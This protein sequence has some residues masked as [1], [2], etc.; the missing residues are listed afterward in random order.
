MSDKREYYRRPDVVAGYDAWRFGSAGGRYVD[1]LERGKVLELLRAVPRDAPVLDMPCGT[2]RLLPHLIGAGF[3]RVT[4]ADASPG[5]LAAARASAPS[6]EL[7]QQDALD[8]TFADAS[9][10]AIVALRFAFHLEDPAP[11][12]REVRRLLRPGGVFVFDSIR[13]T[14]RGLFPL[15]DWKLGGRIWTHGERKVRRAL[16]ELDLTVSR[17]CRA[18]ALPSLAYRF[19]PG[20]LVGPLAALERCLPDAIFTKTFYLVSAER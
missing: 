8:S 18:L 14:P 7:V 11:L 5:M 9:F 16:Q 20:S 4:G 13:W 1:E 6:V 12:F 10:E 2:G 3:S 19:L 17:T 15:L